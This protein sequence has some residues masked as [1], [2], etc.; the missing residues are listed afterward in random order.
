[1]ASE[2]ARLAGP[3]RDRRS[4]QNT[5]RSHTRVRISG[6]PFPPEMLKEQSV[7]P[8][9]VFLVCQ[10]LTTDSRKWRAFTP[11]LRITNQGL[12]T[13]TKHICLPLG[14]GHHNAVVLVLAYVDS[15][16]TLSAQICP[17]SGHSMP[18]ASRVRTKAQ[19]ARVNQVDSIGN[20]QQG[21]MKNRMTKGEGS[22]KEEDRY[23]T[24]RQPSA[25]VRIRLSSLAY[26]THRSV[27]YS[28]HQTA[29]DGHQ[30]DNLA[31]AR[32]RVPLPSQ[33]PV[34]DE[35]ESTLGLPHRN[36]V[37]AIMTRRKIPE[38]WLI[39]SGT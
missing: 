13:A 26:S 35:L 36:V 1:M 8:R 34:W 27:R 25:A 16:R 17:Y 21:H 12:P 3:G 30:L 37:G 6:G 11:F 38:T 7:L 28:S 10:S 29:M 33:F 14:K 20:G 19:I 4:S 15:S 9:G 2:P 32:I 31:V 39:G 5:L 23:N 22:P 24:A 18:E